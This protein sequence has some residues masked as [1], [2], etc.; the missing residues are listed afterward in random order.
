MPETEPSLSSQLKDLTLSYASARN[1]IDLTA[2]GTD[3]Q[4]RAVLNRALNED[5]DLVSTLLYGVFLKTGDAIDEIM[6]SVMKS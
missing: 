2:S 5:F 3:D 1:P 6:S 4:A